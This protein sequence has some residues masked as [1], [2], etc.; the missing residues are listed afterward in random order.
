MPKRYGN[1][2]EPFVRHGH[3]AFARTNNLEEWGVGV[4]ERS[5]TTRPCAT[6]LCI[7]WAYAFGERA[8][9]RHSRQTARD[10]EG[11]GEGDGEE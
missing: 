7:S 5:V 3:F 2:P 10:G 6:L 1:K 11:D 4:G 9:R 8:F